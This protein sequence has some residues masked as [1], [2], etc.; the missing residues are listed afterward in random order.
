MRDIDWETIIGIVVVGVM[1]ALIV[2]VVGLLVVT[3]L[4]YAGIDATRGESTYTGEAVDSE[5]E[6]GLIF[7]T[8]QIHLKTDDRSSEAET[9]CVHPDNRDEQVDVLRE[10]ARGDDRVTITHSRPYFVPIWECEA[11]TSIVRDVEV[12]DE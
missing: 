4:P 12:H 10:A 1:A 5:N 7:Q 9:F 8:T 11:G 6:R 2:M 3:L